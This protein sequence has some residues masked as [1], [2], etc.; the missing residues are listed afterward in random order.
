MQCKENCAFL[1][2]LLLDSSFV[3]NKLENGILFSVYLYFSS[4]VRNNL[5][6]DVASDGIWGKHLQ[7]AISTPC[8]QW[9]GECKYKRTPS[10]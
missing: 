5:L 2:I 3:A 1:S 4:E 6:R 8:Q 10:I 9:E 7:R